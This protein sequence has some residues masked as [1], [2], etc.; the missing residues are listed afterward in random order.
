MV[1][2]VTRKVYLRPTRSPMRPKI[3]APKGRTRN[4]AAYAPNAP[5]SAAVW[6]PGGKNRAAKNGARMA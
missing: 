2:M 6:F 4:P 3:S 5:S 1:T